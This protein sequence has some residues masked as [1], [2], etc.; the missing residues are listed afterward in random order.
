MRKGLIVYQSKYG[1][2]KKYVDMLREEIP[3]DVFAT[4]DCGKLALEEYDW[5]ILAGGIYA[6]GISGLHQLQKRYHRRPNQRFA[7]FC[8]G[9]S[10]FDENAL[11]EI[12]ARNLRGDLQNAPVFY[13]RGAWDESKMSWKDRTLCGL[14]R[15]A[16]AK[17]NN[18]SDEPWIRALLLSAGKACDWTDKGYLDPLLE[19]IRTGS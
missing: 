17:K 18:A 9:A 11:A 10:P 1:A 3:C 6:G 8:V 15:K 19:F 7:V 2:T 13:G 12:K 14:L 4:S 5:I 16:V